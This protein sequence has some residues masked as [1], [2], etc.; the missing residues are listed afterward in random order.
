MDDLDER[1]LL[2][3][4][5]K[6]AGLLLLLA[7]CLSAS[8]LHARVFTSRT[9]D[10]FNPSTFGR[11]VY[12]TVMEIN[13]GKAEVS[14]VACDDG[15]T[16]VQATVQHQRDSKFRAVALSAGDEKPALLV[17]VVQSQAEKDA[18]QSQRARHRLADVPVPSDGVVLGTLRSMDTRTTFERLVS[19][20]GKEEI[21]RFF[22]QSMNREGWL[23][24][25]GAAGKGGFLF[26]VKGADICMVMVAPQESNG[27]TGITLLHKQGAVN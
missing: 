20:L 11:L 27:E 18:S 14:V 3:M 2:S 10:L 13:E 21:V 7:G 25:V 26:Y 12:K 24:L 8:L 6:Y 19:R 17:T 9:V 5:R 4:G 1:D 15:L 22:E 23:K 16:A